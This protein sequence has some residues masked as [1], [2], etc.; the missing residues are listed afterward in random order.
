MII[1]VTSPDWFLEHHENTTQDMDKDATKMSPSTTFNETHT[2]HHHH[3]SKT[4]V[5]NV[6]KLFQVSESIP[7]ST[8]E[9]ISSSHLHDDTTSFED[10]QKSP[11]L[12]PPLIITSTKSNF[13]PIK[14]FIFREIRKP[15]K[16][17]L[18]EQMYSI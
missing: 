11:G 3:L 2:D 12:P 4:Q 1:A 10:D 15:S 9:V 7:D 16:S 6:T 17:K 14:A 13:S 18:L 5:Q 8:Y